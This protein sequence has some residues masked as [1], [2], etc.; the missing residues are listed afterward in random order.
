M[1]ETLLRLPLA[2]PL[3]AA[4]VKEWL[5]DVA[6][7]GLVFLHSVPTVRLVDDDDGVVIGWP[8]YKNVRNGFMHV[9]G[10]NGAY[11]FADVA[12]RMR[13]RTEVA[14]ALTSATTFVGHSLATELLD[15]PPAR[16]QAVATSLEWELRSY[17]DFAPATGN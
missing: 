5:E 9:A 14:L 16:W 2:A 12:S 7:S 15:S 6:A 1:R 11:S 3:P 8:E 17:E 13:N 10:E 4:A